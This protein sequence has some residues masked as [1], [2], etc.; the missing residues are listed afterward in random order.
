VYRA[1]DAF[2]PKATFSTWLYRIAVNHSLNVLRAKKRRA[3]MKRLSA[4]GGDQHEIGLI[5]DHANNP[6]Y[7][8]DRQE[9]F[10]LLHKMLDSLK[11]EQ[12]VAI[13]L[14]RFEGLSYKEIAEVMNISISAVESRI[15]RGRQKL[16]KLLEE[17]NN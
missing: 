5:A 11:E 8:I 1:L 13:V 2:K 10:K 9:R 4:L 6:E 7:V 12:R 17:I 15:F 14:H 16:A 3:W